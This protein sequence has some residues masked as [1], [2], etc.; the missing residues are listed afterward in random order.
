MI[1]P[2]YQ[3]LSKSK[4][5]FKRIKNKIFVSDLCSFIFKRFTLYRICIQN[6]TYFFQW[7]SLSGTDAQKCAQIFQ[8]WI[9]KLEITEHWYFFSLKYYTSDWEMW[10]Y[11]CRS[12]QVLQEFCLNDLDFNFQAKIFAI[13]KM[14]NGFRIDFVLGMIAILTHPCASIGKFMYQR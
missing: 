7:T 3:N 4:S 5:I 11:C 10:Y 1:K 8:K 2:K 13:E 14:L 6:Y 12:S 9:T